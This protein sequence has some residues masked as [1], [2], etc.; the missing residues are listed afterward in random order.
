MSSTI[1]GRTFHKILDILEMSLPA[2]QHDLLSD[3]AWLYE[4]KRQ[5][6][7]EEN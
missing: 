4:V 1:N 5:T 7:E 2:D 6:T 3:L